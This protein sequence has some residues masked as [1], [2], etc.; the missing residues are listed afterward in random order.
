MAEPEALNFTE[1]QTFAHMAQPQFW[2]VEPRY[3]SDSDRHA[4]NLLDSRNLGQSLIGI[5][6]NSK[7]SASYQEASTGRWLFV[8]LTP[9]EHSIVTHSPRDLGE[10]AVNRARSAQ[11]LATNGGEER[12]RRAG[13]HALEGSI[14]RMSLY[15]GCLESDIDKLGRFSEYVANQ[16]LRRLRG[17]NFKQQMGWLRHHVFSSMIQAAGYQRGWVKGSDKHKRAEKAMDDRLFLDRHNNQHLK[18]WQDT[19]GLATLYWGHKW[20]LFKTKVHQA[21]HEIN[22][23]QA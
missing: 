3:L 19:F 4:V 8:A 7:V 12:S 14:G 2:G 15:L 13:V 17:D 10:R 21:Q 9:E 6:R 1:Q 11:P 16:D 18:N 22:S 20:A 5:S 23:L